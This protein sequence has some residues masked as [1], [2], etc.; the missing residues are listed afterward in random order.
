MNEVTL[1]QVPE[2]DQLKVAARLLGYKTMPV[3]IQKFIEDPYYLGDI[4]KSLYPFWKEYL[5]KIYPSP[6]HTN[7]PILVFVGGIGTGKSTM[8][9]VMSMYLMHRLMCL[10]N[11]HHTFGLMPGKRLK[12][13]FFTYTSGLAES[14][15]LGPISE[16][17]EIS[18][19]FKD[20]MEDGSIDQFDI[21]ADGT[22]GN[23]NIGSDVIFYNLSEINFIN[24]DKA[25]EKL[26]Q[27]LKRFD[28]RFG[29]FRPYFGHVIIDTS[30]QG[31]DSIAD[32]FINNNPYGDQ[33]LVIRT[34]QWIVR[35]HLNYYG[36]AGW[37]KVYAGDSMHSPFIISDDKPE[38]ADLDPDRL[39]E[40]P[41]ELRADFEFDLTTALQ[42]KAGIST[43]SSDKFFP[44]I[45]HLSN[46]FKLPMYGDDVIKLDFYDTSD[47]LSIR[48]D[49]FIR[50]IPKD[51]IIYI[52][53]DIGVTGDNTGL[54]ISYFENWRTING[55]KR[56]I[57][58]TP[59]CIGINRYEDQETPIYHL[60][61]FIYY[62]AEQFEIGCFSA[63]QFASRQLFQNL[64]LRGIPNKYLSV[65]RTDEAYV[66]FKNLAN[67]ECL[68][69]C[70]NS[71]LKHEQ[72]DLR[73]IGNKVDHLPTNSKDLSD[74]CVA[75]IY[76]CYLDIDNA[77]NISNK[78]N[79]K[80][81]NKSIEQ[82]FSVVEDPIDD[83]MKDIYG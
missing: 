41:E 45:T 38:T 60:E 75:S 79:I 58:K 48:L 69:I 64:N 81:L 13:S 61:E 72:F 33:V 66:F 52:H 56:P 77:S 18:P 39:I 37:F 5:A 36:N 46:C 24:P 83:M 71:L 26:D 65:D 22:R 54:A 55:V 14:D 20:K 16:W 40:V 9:R 19:Y 31:D 67:F 34:N 1:S 12:F 2:Q 32:D 23:A 47:L 49:P 27:A 62:L 43:T 44:D 3:T 63:D 70:D 53:Y 17:M 42:D 6:I 74:A 68:E 8:A 59:L 78:Y 11:P 4:C 80:D 57:I 28:S 51:R 10:R 21:V 50:R 7:Y 15:F 76:S 35:K 82:S 30:S 25:Y 29:R 73:R